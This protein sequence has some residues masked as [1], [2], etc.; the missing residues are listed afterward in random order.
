V[1]T[2]G[3]NKM[4]RVHRD[5]LMFR[6]IT[7]NHEIVVGFK[8]VGHNKCVFC[9]KAVPLGDTVCDGCFDKG[10]SISKK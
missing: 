9:G 8:N 6:W 4:V 10:K 1:F 3:G 5:N 2:S 7:K